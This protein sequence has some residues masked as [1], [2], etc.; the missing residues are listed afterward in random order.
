MLAARPPPCRGPAA[1]ARRRGSA[2]SRRRRGWPR[3]ACSRI[4]SASSPVGAHAL[5]QPGEEVA[6]LAGLAGPAPDLLDDL[7]VLRGR[8][9]AAAGRLGGQGDAVAL[10]G[11]RDGREAGVDEL[12]GRRAL[13]RHQVE[14]LADAVQRAVDHRHHAARDAGVL[15]LE[16]E[17]VALQERV[18][19][20]GLAVV[21]GGGRLH[22]LDRTADQVDAGVVAGRRVVRQ[23]VVVP[24]DAVVG[25]GDR[26]EGAVVLDE[27]R[28]TARRRCGWREWCR[29]RGRP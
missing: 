2:R 26:V 15:H 23:A 7:G 27:L 6:A 28:R 1:R 22:R 17:A 11:A 29:S 18:A 5:D 3:A 24:G 25:R 12:V 16:L 8:G 19:G 20:R 21:D 14:D 4:R 10:D 9:H 13:G